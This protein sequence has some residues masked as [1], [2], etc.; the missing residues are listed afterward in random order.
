MMVRILRNNGTVDRQGR[1]TVIVGM[2]TYRRAM[3]TFVEPCPR[4]DPRTQIRAV[5]N[6]LHV[7]RRLG[8]LVA[9]R[10]EDG[11][12]TGKEENCR[13]VQTM[14]K[15]V[16]D[17]GERTGVISSTEDWEK[18]VGEKCVGSGNYRILVWY[19]RDGK[20]NMEGYKAFG[21]FGL[22]DFKI[23]KGPTEMCK[24]IIDIG[25]RRP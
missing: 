11:W 2:S 19:M 14:L 25:Y 20:R 7:Y 3:T 22:P 17:F 24:S 10:A 18:V 15:V 6:A 5:V 21:G 13:F 12:G 1:L 8:I 9:V 4:L 16:E 23:F